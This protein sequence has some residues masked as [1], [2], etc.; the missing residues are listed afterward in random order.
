MQN[1]EDNLKQYLEKTYDA[2]LTDEEVRQSKD[3]IISFFD[4]LIHIDQR[5]RKNNE[6]HS[7]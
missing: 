1:A 6:S 3:R 2:N 7:E 4:L 5:H